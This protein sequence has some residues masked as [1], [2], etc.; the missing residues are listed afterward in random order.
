MFLIDEKEKEGMSDVEII[1]E[2][3]DEKDKTDTEANEL[4]KKW[5]IKYSLQK[6]GEKKYNTGTSL[7]IYENKFTVSGIRDQLV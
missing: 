1:K 6:K 7:D 2:I 5:K 4:L 3:S